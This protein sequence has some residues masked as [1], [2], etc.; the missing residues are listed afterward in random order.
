[1][2]GLAMAQEPPLLISAAFHAQQA[3]EKLLKG[4]LVLWGL[5]F[6]KIH[7]M[8]LLLQ[9]VG[10]VEGLSEANRPTLEDFTPWAVDTRYPLPDDAALPV[11]QEL[12]GA[13]AAID[14]LATLVRA[15][16]DTP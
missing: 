4:L 12:A 1:M 10:P 11:A 5:P 14:R 16:I 6:P 13:L 15:A 7:D 3:G 9:R 2:A 8:A